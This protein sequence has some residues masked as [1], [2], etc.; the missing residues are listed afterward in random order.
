MEHYFLKLQSG[1][2]SFT[3]FERPYPPTTVIASSIVQ[4]WLEGLF[5]SEFLILQYSSAALYNSLLTETFTLMI[6]P[7]SFTPFGR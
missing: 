1:F 2:N 6:L 4:F 3:L 5:S 7:L